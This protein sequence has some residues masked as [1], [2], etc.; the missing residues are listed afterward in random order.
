MQGCG[1]L[2]ASLSPDDRVWSFSS[3]G[4]WERARDPLHR[5]WESFTPVHAE[6]MRA[7]LLDDESD[8]TNEDLAIRERET[9]K[10]GAGLGIS[11]GVAMAEA[12]GRPIG[13]IRAVHGGTT[14]DQWSN[15]LKGRGGHSLHGAM[16]ERIRIAGGNP[17]GVLWYQGESHALLAELGQTYAE[18]FDAWIS[19]LRTDTGIAEL[20]VIAVQIGRVAEPPDRAG[21]W[22]GWDMVREALRT[23]PDRVPGTAVTSAIDLPLTDLIH[24]STEAGIR[25]GRR[26]ARLAL[27]VTGE[28]PHCTGPSLSTASLETTGAGTRDRVRL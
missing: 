15:T 11:F 12:T 17:K 16:I 1:W 19:A 20:P 18:R 14:L 24:I 21:I 8:L 28:A 26:L 27:S 7:L 5:H 4:R 25:L 3:A 23:L 6:I 22:R 2:E 10:K 13:L 9:G